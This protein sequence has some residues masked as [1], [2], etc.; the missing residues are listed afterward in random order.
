[1]TASYTDRYSAASY[2]LQLLAH[3]ETKPDQQGVS[4]WLPEQTL[5]MCLIKHRTEQSLQVAQQRQAGL[6]MSH[7][8]PTARTCATY[9]MSEPRRRTLTCSSASFLRDKLKKGKRCKRAQGFAQS[10]LATAKGSITVS[11]CR[12]CALRQA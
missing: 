7:S 1:L 8:V 9:F 2:L 10:G 3:R 6:P 4:V 11:M 12:R 5:Q